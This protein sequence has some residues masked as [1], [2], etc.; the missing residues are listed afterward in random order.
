MEPE[1]IKKIKQQ[2][3][4]EARNRTGADKTKVTINPAEWNAIQAGAI[5]PTKLEKIIANSDLDTLKALALPKKALKVST[6]DLR[7]AQS[8]LKSGHT[9]AE[10]ADALGVGLTHT[11]GSSK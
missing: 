3:L 9:Q 1:D 7:R 8:M 10:V 2:A 11:Q 5:A 6:S 4:R